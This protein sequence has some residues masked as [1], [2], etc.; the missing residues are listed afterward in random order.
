MG[1]RNVFWYFDPEFPKMGFRGT[2]SIKKVP[3]GM[4][5]CKY[6]RGGRRISFFSELGVE[7]IGPGLFCN[8]VQ[9]KGAH[10]DSHHAS[11][12]GGGGDRVEFSG[13]QEERK[14]NY[15]AGE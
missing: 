12:R 8:Y 11:M 13:T 2:G 5:G 3:N 6:Y 15:P 14:K 7:G 9:E 10:S 4:G 1:S